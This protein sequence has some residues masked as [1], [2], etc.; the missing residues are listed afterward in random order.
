MQF[1][2]T[3]DHDHLA[4]VPFSTAMAHGLAPD[5]G[6]Y[7][8]ATFPA[9]DDDAIRGGE[10]SLGTVARQVLAPFFAEDRSCGSPC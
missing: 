4:A 3:R 2:S 1:V 10:R 6:L 9:V 7:V 8:P 5:G